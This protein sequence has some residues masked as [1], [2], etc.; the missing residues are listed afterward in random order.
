MNKDSCHFYNFRDCN[1]KSQVGLGRGQ[2][3]VRQGSEGGLGRRQEGTGRAQGCRGAFCQGCQTGVTGSPGWGLEW[4][5][6]GWLVIKTIKANKRRILF[7]AYLS[8]S[9]VTYEDMCIIHETHQASYNPG[10]G[11]LQEGTMGMWQGVAM[12]SLKFHPGPPCPTLPCPVGRSPLKQLF[13]G[14][15][16]HRAGGLQ[17]SATP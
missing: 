13:Q 15:P 9:S 11:T 14:W 4:V 17:P 16:A 5:C 2:E 7:F 6:G 3:G 8:K 1:L 10:D 12:D